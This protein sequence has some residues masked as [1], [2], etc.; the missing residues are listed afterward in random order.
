MNFFSLLYTFPKDP[1]KGWH[2]ELALIEPGLVFHGFPQHGCPPLGLS[3]GQQFS[4]CPL[5]DGHFFLSSLHCQPHF[6]KHQAFRPKLLGNFPCSKLSIAPSF[7]PPPSPKHPWLDVQMRGC[8]EAFLRDHQVAL[9]TS[10]LLFGLQ[11]SPG[12][13]CSINNQKQ[14]NLSLTSTFISTHQYWTRFVKSNSILLTH[15]CTLFFFQT[16]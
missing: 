15:S 4:F 3:R 8:V 12:S 13:L 7:C 9:T 11:L 2:L 6:L 16:L 5:G 14:A 1:L 10:F